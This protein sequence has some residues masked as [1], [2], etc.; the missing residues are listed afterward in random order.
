MKSH[1][2]VEHIE[3]PKGPAAINILLMLYM[4]AVPLFTYYPSLNLIPQLIFVVAF[5]G[6]AA[7]LLFRN[8]KFKVDTGIL[9]FSCF[10]TFCFL[11]LLW[12]KSFLSSFTMTWTLIQLL[13]LYIL[14]YSYIS[15]YDCMDA[16]ILGL[17]IS[18]LILA[19]VVISFYG[20]TEYISLM[21]QGYR[22][23][24]MINNVNVIGLYMAVTFIIGFYY[25]YIKG[26]NWVYIVDVL[27]LFVG[28][29]TGSRKCLVMM[30]L[31]IGLIILMQYREKM[32][33]KAFGRL[34]LVIGIAVAVI[35]WLTTL[36]IF[37][38]T[39]NRI[40]SM[41]G[42]SDTAHDGSTLIREEMRAIGWEYFSEHPFSGLGIGA[43]WV[44]TEEKL[45]WSTYLH[46]NFIELL[47]CT[48][49]IGFLL[50][51]SICA[52][53]IIGLYK[54]AVKTE[55]AAATLMLTIIFSSLIM[56]YGA[57]SYYSKMTYV[58][59]AMASGAV[60]IG[61]RKEKEGNI[62]EQNPQKVEESAEKAHSVDNVSD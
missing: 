10:V 13:I 12:S 3:R 60:I 32:N 48:G 26:K 42:A 1:K 35:C 49:I 21:L 28:F 17:F 62:S 40:L 11:S 39:F 58:Y 52:Y 22:L 45:G 19:V 53:L 4:A 23:G 20:L 41:L 37:E 25:G 33:V 14:L 16:L 57:V 29:G 8:K 55:N 36:P 50:Y 38:G 46:N 44:L 18:G 2:T 6:I 5:G 59:F 15:N 30:A 9:L 56:D 24:G 43:S 27:P 61:K 31:G 51:Y 47:A 7:L 54:Q 34:L